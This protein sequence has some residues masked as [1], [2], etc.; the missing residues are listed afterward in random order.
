MNWVGNSL[1]GY[2]A[3]VRR[4]IYTSLALRAIVAG[5]V[6]RWIFKRLIGK[7]RVK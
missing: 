7:L 2:Y 6:L 5:W 4:A 3:A 1:E